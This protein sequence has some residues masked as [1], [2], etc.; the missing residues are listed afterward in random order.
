MSFLKWPPK[1][2]VDRAEMLHSLGASFAQPLANQFLKEIVFSATPLAAVNR[3]EDI[4]HE[5][6]EKMTTSDL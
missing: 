6:G 4:M 2:W 3:Y 5:L 1:R